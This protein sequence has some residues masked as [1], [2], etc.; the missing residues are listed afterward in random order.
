MLIL[1]RDFVAFIDTYELWTNATVNSIY[2]KFRRC[3]KS[4]VRSS[5]DEI[6]DGEPKL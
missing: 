2:G 3:F 6:I 1:I 5:W 4:D